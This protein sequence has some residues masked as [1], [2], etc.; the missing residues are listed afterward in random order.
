MSLTREQVES[1]L[2][3]I[4][5]Q[6][7]MELRGQ[8][9]V[10]AYDITAHLTRIF[11]FGGWDKEILSMVKL[12]DDPTQTQAGKPAWAVTF[13]CTL[14]LT[15]RDPQGQKVAIYEDGA[16]G[17]STQPQ[18]GEAL[19]MAMKSAISY[20]LKRCA[21]DLG[22]Q[23][24]LSLYNNGRTAGLV[25]NTLV[26]PQGD[27]YVEVD[28]ESHIERPESEGNDERR[29][30]EI[31]VEELVT[32]S[33]PQATQSRPSVDSRP[34]NE[35][36]AVLLTDPQ[37]RMIN[38]IF[39]KLGFGDREL[40]HDKC[41]E[42]LGLSEGSVTSIAALTKAQAHKIIDWLQNEQDSFDANAR[43]L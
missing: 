11:G 42:I 10:P 17:S 43:Q 40:I 16:C 27:N 33:R 38:S 36:D 26:K 6:R 35:K 12:V 31:P 29:S 21:K 32:V 1:L 20:A 18:H 13:S 3:P 30:E 9:H 28:L 22:D 15:I 41:A 8:S 24:G 37:K 39:A 23:F 34:F 5:P 7:V 2:K 4:Y 19:D 25:M 14:R